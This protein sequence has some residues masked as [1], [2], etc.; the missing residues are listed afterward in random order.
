M[1]NPY[2]LA[3]ALVE[4]GKTEA[5]WK[6]LGAILNDD[7]NDLPALITASYLFLRTGALPQAYHFARRSTELAPQEDSTWTNYGNAA[8]QMCLNDEAE[9]YYRR[10]LSC[11][12]SAQARNM[13]WLNLCGLYIDTGK[14]EKAEGFA[15]KLLAVAPESKSALANLGFCQLARRDWA[16]GWKN[17]HHTVGSSW[18]KRVRYK[19]EPEWDGA[20]GQNVVVY[21][22]QGIGDEISF[23]SMIPDAAARCKK[24]IFDCDGRLEGLFRR[25][26][27]MATVYGT[28]VKDEKWAPEDRHIDASLSVG[29]LGEFVR[30]KDDDFTGARYLVPCPVRSEQWRVHFGRYDSDVPRRPVIGIA[31]TGGVPKT[32]A[33]NRR[34]SLEDLLPVLNLPARFV[35]LQYKDASAEI[36]KLT[37]EHPSVDLVQYPWATL[38]EDYDDTAA[39]IAACDYVLCIQTAVAHTAGGLGVPV[40]VLLPTATSWRYGTSGDTVPWYRSLKI[41][42]QKT[43]GEWG[44]EIERAARAIADQFGL[45]VGARKAP[46]DRN[47][48]HG[49]HLLRANGQRHHQADGSQPSS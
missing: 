8:A 14:F 48:R 39:L 9:T 2:A 3:A 37:A 22:D 16:E 38:T 31:W 49:Q 28:R 29:Q 18:R 7:P 24:L 4:N 26:F 15:R 17:Y 47:V 6:I 25:S 40:T 46:R 36:A 42:R 44:D 13:L 41:I 19:D 43:S 20:P 45:S 11:A 23:A 30:T 12:K 33:R 5:A 1:D 10:G 32:N 35:S 27:P 21:A 34:V